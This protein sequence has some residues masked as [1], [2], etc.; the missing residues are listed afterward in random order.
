[1]NHEWK[2]IKLLADADETILKAF[3]ER[4][5]PVSYVE[6]E[7]VLWEGDECQAVYFITSGMVEIYRTAIDGRVHTLRILRAGDSFNLVPVLMKKKKNLANVR[8]LEP[9]DLLVLGR[10]DLQIILARHP[11]FAV[12]ILKEIAGRLA[13]MTGMASDLALLTVRQRTAVFL[14]REAENILIDAGRR[15]TQDDMARQIG[16]VRDVIGRTLRDFEGKGLV[17]RDRG[18]ISLINREGLERTADG[19]E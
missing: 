3:D 13:D 14:M 6:G 15:W 19:Y 7:P 2:I 4:G 12:H 17:L 5:W 18:N 10:E 9:T 1:M 16:T 11:N 8:C